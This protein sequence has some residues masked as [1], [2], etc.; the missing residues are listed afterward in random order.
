MLV[1]KTVC[2]LPLIQAGQS[3][4][5]T[6]Y[7]HLLP[8]SRMCKTL[9]PWPVYTPSCFVYKEGKLQCV[10]STAVTSWAASFTLLTITIF[11]IRETFQVL[12]C[13]MKYKQHVSNFF[14]QCTKSFIN[15]L[16]QVAIIIMQ[17]ERRTCINS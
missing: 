11:K 9:L 6:T 14:F 16:I 7:L 5:L 1:G 2:N 13:T 17:H 4:K 12:Y 15:V 10:P 3:M 8:R